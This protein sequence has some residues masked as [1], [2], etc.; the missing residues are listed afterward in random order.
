MEENKNESAENKLTSSLNVL[1]AIC[2]EYF[3]STSIIYST[4]KC[5]H[6][7]HHQC[8]FRWLKRSHTCPQCRAN[9]HNHNVHR[10]FLNFSEPTKID[11]VDTEPIKSFEWM[12]TEDSVTAEELAQ[13]GFVLGIDKEGDPLYAARVYLENDLLPAYYVPKLKGAYAAWNCQSHF[14]TD[15]I[16]LLHVNNDNADYKWVSASNGEI[17]PNALATG[18]C[19]NGETLY[20]ARA[21]CN[22]RIRYGKLHPSHGCAYVPHKDKEISNRNYEVLVRIHKDKE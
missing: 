9:A 10:L 3:K 2:S 8:L 4:S 18:Y 1:C 22:G 5:G 13:L 14:L 20:T 6:V 19:E 21:F 17:P 11:Q 16:E 12:Y 15:D 7:F